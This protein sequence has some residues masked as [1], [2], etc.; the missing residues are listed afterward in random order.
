MSRE[1]IVAFLRQVLSFCLVGGVG[2]V[3]DVSIFNLLRLTL[4]APGAVH[5]GPVLAKVVSTALAIGVNWVGNRFWT[6]RE[7][8][9]EDVGR[10]AVEFVLA[11]LAGL[12][13]SVACLWVSHYLLGFRTVLDDNLSANLVG[14]GLGTVVRFVLYRWWVYGNRAVPARL[15]SAAPQ[16][17][18]AGL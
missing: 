14:L 15:T 5:G 17:V 8:R 11:S 16:K 3:V 6:F 1:S 4:L 13:V 10:E 7:R 12:V 2:L 18:D 9:P